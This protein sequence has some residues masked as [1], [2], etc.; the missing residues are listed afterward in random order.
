[1][2]TATAEVEADV[3]DAAHRAAIDERL[4]GAA[5]TGTLEWAALL[6]AADGADPRVVAHRMRA[7]ELPVRPGVSSGG[8]AP[9]WAPELHALDFEWYFERSC[10]AMLAARL[11]E[12]GPRVLCLGAPTVAFALLDRPDCERVTLIDANPLVIERHPATDRL[13]AIV[14]DLAAARV[15]EGRY[16]AVLFDAPWY[17]AELLRWLAVAAG[18]VRTGGRILFALPRPLHRPSA[19]ADR[20]LVLAAARRLGRARIEPR[21]LAYE[22]PRFEHEALGAAGVSVPPS[23]RRADLVELVRDDAPAPAP[24]APAPGPR[25]RRF[26]IG[27]QVVKLDLDAPSTPGDP[28]SPLPGS[29]GFRYA[30]ISTRDPLRS[31]IGLWTSRSRVARVRRPELVAELLEESA[32]IG[33]LTTL[34]DTAALRSL[35]PGRRASALEAL[36]AVLGSR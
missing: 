31:S 12:H 22:T 13:R 20:R 28:I 34:P 24:I 5:S 15:E 14:D 36:R 25:W 6:D 17:P 23:W 32:R 8:P 21:A 9:G 10:A 2:S 19:D 27:A 18:A 1:M 11:V 4:R 35:E 16:D 33:D 30:S 26:V 29:G 7:L 3:A